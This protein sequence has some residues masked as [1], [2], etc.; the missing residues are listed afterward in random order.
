MNWNELKRIE[1]YGWWMTDEEYWMI[2]EWEMADIW[3]INGNKWEE[4]T[5]KI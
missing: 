1:I 5:M 3:M 2:D 4:M